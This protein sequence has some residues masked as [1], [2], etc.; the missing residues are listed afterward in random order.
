MPPAE[1]PVSEP[2]AL[3]VPCR[4]SAPEIPPL[5]VTTPAVSTPEPPC[6]TENPFPAVVVRSTVPLAPTPITPARV[7][8][9]LSTRL[10]APPPVVLSVPPRVPPPIWAIALAVLVSVKLLAV[11]VRIDTPASVPVCVTAPVA[12][13]VG[14]ASSSNGR[15]PLS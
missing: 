7:N 4:I 6:E 9:W 2:I 3:D 8:A 12:P 1:R 10:I 11:P 14:V 5:L 13:R 15:L